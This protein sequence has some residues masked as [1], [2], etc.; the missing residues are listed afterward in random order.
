MPNWP[1]SK[2]NIEADNANY[3]CVSTGNIVGGSIRSR[4]YFGIE[5]EY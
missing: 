3:S 4:T 2:F 1:D 5:C